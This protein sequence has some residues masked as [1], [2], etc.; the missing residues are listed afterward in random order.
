[1]M[2]RWLR[3]REV[4]YAGGGGVAFLESKRCF[5]RSCAAVIRVRK[6]SIARIASPVRNRQC[7]FST[8]TRVIETTFGEASET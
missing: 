3:G 5:P 6:C 4:A 8:F 7:F 2:L 1:M